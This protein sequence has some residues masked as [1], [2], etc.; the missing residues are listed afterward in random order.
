MA[1]RLIV[2]L[3]NPGTQYAATRHNVG[4]WFV[5]ALTKRWQISLKAE[6]KF[7]GE[8]VKA[9]LRE[10]ECWFCIPSTYMNESGKAIASLAKFYKIAPEEILVAHDELDFPAG[11]IRLKAGGGAGGHN[12]L[13]DTI[14]KLGSKDFLRLRIGIGH[15]GHKDRV[16][17]YVLG[18]PS[19]TD[20]QA[21]EQAIE[22]GLDVVDD[23]VV[24]DFERACH[25]LHSA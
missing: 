20:K 19:A 5:H 1:V 7:Y 10:H 3:A 9:T 6:K 17:P 12:G 23:L 22:Q 4:A 14:S 16:T 24:G 15:P 25:S 11:T 13:R 2:G 21:I 8:V 18:K